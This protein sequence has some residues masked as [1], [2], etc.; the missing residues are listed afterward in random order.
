[1][2]VKRS[3]V[4]A[5]PP[6][7]KRLLAR[8]YDLVQTKRANRTLR[9]RD[10]P[11]PDPDPD[12]QQHVVLLVVDALRCDVV[13]EETMPFLASMDGTTSAL[14]ASPWTFPAVSSLLT[15]AYPHEHGA[16]RAPTVAEEGFAS[17]NGFRTIG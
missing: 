3:L 11:S 5:L 12:A 4:T 13:T 14:T 6:S 7:V 16:I 2:N 10:R 8:A 15:G 1:M 17:P 9:A